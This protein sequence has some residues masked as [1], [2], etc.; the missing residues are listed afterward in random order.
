[1]AVLL[2]IY[3]WDWIHGVWIAWRPFTTTYW[4]SGGCHNP[5]SRLDAK[6]GLKSVQEE[7]NN[8][9]HARGKNGWT[10]GENQRCSP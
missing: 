4:E 1:M 8:D 9:Y 10:V 5:M 3:L 2:L 6:F 7:E